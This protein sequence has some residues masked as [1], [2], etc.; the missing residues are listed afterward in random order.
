MLRF[1]HGRNRREEPYP[2]ANRL[3]LKGFQA[4]TKIWH[5]KRMGQYPVG[6]N[7]INAG[8]DFG[9]VAVE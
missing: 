5:A 4:V 2:V 8:T 7:D 1:R 9:F 6:L 3:Y